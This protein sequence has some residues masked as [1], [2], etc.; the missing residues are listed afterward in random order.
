MRITDL[1]LYV[2][3]V[4]G[5]KFL[6]CGDEDEVQEIA[7]TYCHEAGLE[8]EELTIEPFTDTETVFSCDYVIK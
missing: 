4:N 5:Y 7:E 1:N 3:N 8:K 2:G 6:I